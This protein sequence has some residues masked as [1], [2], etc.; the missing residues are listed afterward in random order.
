LGNEGFSGLETPFGFRAANLTDT[1]R[2]KSFRLF[3]A[4]VRNLLDVAQV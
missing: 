4:I 1:V 2:F 3:S